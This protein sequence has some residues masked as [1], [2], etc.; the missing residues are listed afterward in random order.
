MTANN[1]A[2]EWEIYFDKVT[3]SDSPGYED[4][5][6]SLLLTKAEERNVEKI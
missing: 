5:E 2:D 3:N 6:I 4:S 1:M